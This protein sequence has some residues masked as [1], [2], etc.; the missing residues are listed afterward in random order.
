M[1]QD[2]GY[3]GCDIYI[4]YRLVG[5]VIAKSVRMAPLRAGTAAVPFPTGARDFL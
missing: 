3:L 2:A 5:A 1:S 4:V